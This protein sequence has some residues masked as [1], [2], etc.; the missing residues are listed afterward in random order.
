MVLV[1]AVLV[2]LI[3]VAVRLG[4]GGSGLL[5]GD[6]ASHTWALLH[7]PAAALL[8]ARVL[9]DSGTGVCPYLIAVVAGLAAASTRRGRVWHALLAVGVLATGQGVRLVIMEAV[10]RPRPPRADWA[11]Y[12]TGFSLPS[13]HSTSAALSA[14]LLCLA[15]FRRAPRLLNSIIGGLVLVWAVGVGLSRV[16]LGVHWA[17]DVI[18]GWLLAI[19]LLSLCTVTYHWARRRRQRH[20]A[21]PETAPDR[22]N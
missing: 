7:R 3:V 1:P 17:S 11:T 16:Y 12:A 6:A 14:G 18:A 19:T 5:P 20:A 2:V 22:R 10:A 21:G 8:V 13:G 15:M 9:T 4:G